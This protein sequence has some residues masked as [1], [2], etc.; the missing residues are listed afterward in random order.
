MSEAR[1]PIES[2]AQLYERAAQLSADGLRQVL[3]ASLFERLANDSEASVTMFI[4]IKRRGLTV[5]VKWPKE[6]GERPRFPLSFT[7]PEPRS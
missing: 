7:I 3:G 4:D 1:Q 2:V 6:F 5:S